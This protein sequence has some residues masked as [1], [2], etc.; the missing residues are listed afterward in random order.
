MHKRLIPSIAILSLLATTAAFANTVSTVSVASAPGAK[1][2]GN[3]LIGPYQG[4][5]G[6]AASIIYC[7]DLAHNINFNQVANVNVSSIGDLSLTRFGGSGA[8]TVL[9]AAVA[10]AD[11]EK[12]FYL[13]A[14]LGSSYTSPTSFYAGKSVTDNSSN[15]SAT[16]GVNADIQDAMWSIF[17]SA[18]PNA[19]STGVGYW[20]GQAAA[21]YKNFD[22]SHFKILT[23]D[24]SPNGQY[25]G[26]Q[27]LFVDTLGTSQLSP[28]PEPATMMM[29]GAGLAVLGFVGVRRRNRSSRL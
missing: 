29:L 21:N 15:T 18:A 16:S 12:I 8:A 1:D 26:V 20:L 25:H 14:F 23:D 11:Y 13:S 2:S 19:A 6:S 5:F 7:D 10:T 28:T 22:Y 4:T 17:D 3:N 24:S 27:E 9:T